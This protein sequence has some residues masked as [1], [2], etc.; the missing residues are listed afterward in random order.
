[1]KK[2]QNRHALKVQLVDNAE[3]FQNSSAIKVKVEG[4]GGGTID[5]D[6]ELSTTSENPVQNK[7]ITQAVNADHEEIGRIGGEL[8][9][10]QDTLTAGTGI[11]ISEENVISA[12]GGG[13]DNE[14]CDIYTSIISVGSTVV[15]KAYKDEARTQIFTYGD[16]RALYN[17][18]L[19]AA[20]KPIRFVQNTM[21]GYIIDKQQMY[22]AAQNFADYEQLCTGFFVCASKPFYAS[23]DQMDISLPPKVW[24]VAR[25]INMFYNSSLGYTGAYSE[26]FAFTKIKDGGGELLTTSN[27][28]FDEYSRPSSSYGNPGMIW[29]YQGGVDDPKVCELWI[30]VAKDQGYIWV[31]MCEQ[32]WDW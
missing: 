12:T 19:T 6:D 20:L 4:G 26:Q 31:K 24:G 8:A 32:Q 13:G 7:V 9:N 2:V 23:A 27:I 16:L 22:N 17:E 18:D 30:C 11:A 29:I 10:K 25:T 1:M 5:V 3:K 21:D 28:V 15:F 14:Y